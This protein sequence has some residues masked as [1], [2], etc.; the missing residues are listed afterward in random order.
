MARKDPRHTQIY[1]EIKRLRARL[2][3][4]KKELLPTKENNSRN[5]AQG[6]IDDL[7]SQIAWFF[8]DVGEYKKG[9][10]LYQ[11]LLWRTHGEEKY[12]GMARALIE[13]EYYD[14]ARNLL[15]RGLHRFP[16]SCSLLVAMG[17]LH[18][19]LDDDF[20]ALK[21]FEHALRLSPSDKSALF[22]QALSLNGLGY[23]EDAASIL[24]DLLEDN[25]DDPDYLI[26]MGYSHISRGYPEEALHFYKKALATG[27]L[28]WTIYDGLFWTY[29]NMGLKNDAIQIASEGIRKLP[30]SHS[31]LY[32]DLSRVYKEMGW[33]DE[34]RDILKKG[35]EIFPEDKDLTELLKEIEDETD[36]P[37]KG[38]KP[39]ILG[40]LLLSAIINKLKKGGRYQ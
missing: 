27:C 23:Y 39:P 31:C 36:D 14:K 12:N 32:G 6:Y 21:Y 16:E 26:E 25:P 5:M 1:K 7:R 35:L 20:E 11:T 2:Y 34:A 30:D 38:N 40:L 4:A 33:V 18:R 19:R 22:D 29:F 8:L 3:K 28:K 24:K 15:E 13:M 9:L 37:D 10:A 17:L